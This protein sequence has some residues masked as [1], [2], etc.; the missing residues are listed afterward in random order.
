MADEKPPEGTPAPDAAPAFDKA[1]YDAGLAALLKRDATEP[2]AAEETP[3]KPEGEAKPEDKAEDAAEDETDDDV[4]P[5]DKDPKVA[6]ESLRKLQKEKRTFEAYKAT[7]LEKERAVVAREERVAGGE[8]ELVG[9]LKQLQVDPV[10]ALVGNKLLTDDQL[11]YA[12]RQLMLLSP[13]GLK[14]PRSRAEAERLRTE[15]KRDVEA[16]EARA[17]IENIRKEREAEKAQAK[18][19]REL[20][21]YVTQLDASLPTYKA[22]TPLLAKAME[23]DASATKRELY[24]VATE[25]A[26]ANGG[27]LVEP[28][29]VLLAWEKQVREQLARLGFSLPEAAPAGQSKAKTPTAAKK[30]GHEQNGKGAPPAQE[31]A[32]DPEIAKSDDE[33]RAELRRRLKQ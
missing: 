17:E 26:T 29:K 32:G 23:K 9:F 28:G 4:A 33:Y 8:R 7:V 20:N 19:D 1:A 10:G 30:Q 6:E 15:M 2:P 12:A 13:S 18:A 5:E 22:K 16:R 11:D 3:P 31:Q 24:S 27:R 21:T 14:D 25:L